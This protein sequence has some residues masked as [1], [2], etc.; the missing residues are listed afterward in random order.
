MQRR[1]HCGQREAQEHTH[2]GRMDLQEISLLT[3]LL[4]YG[5]IQSTKPQ[6][7]ANEERW[8][9]AIT[10]VFQQHGHFHNSKHFPSVLETT[11]T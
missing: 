10:T 9:Q 11:R 4:S 1:L 6:K 7:R 8:Q 3:S 5:T 2:A